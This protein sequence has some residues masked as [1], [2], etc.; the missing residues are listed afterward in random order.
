MNNNRVTLINDNCVFTENMSVDNYVIIIPKFNYA[1][2][3]DSNSDIRKH[4]IY[5]LKILFIGDID[6][7]NYSVTININTNIKNNIIKN[8]KIDD[9]LINIDFV[10]IFDRINKLKIL[11]YD[12]NIDIFNYMIIT[13]SLFYFIRFNESNNLINNNN[14]NNNDNYEVN[15]EDYSFKRNIYINDLH[16]NEYVIYNNKYYKA[17]LNSGYKIIL[18]KSNNCISLV[19]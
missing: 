17:P 18:I 13:D 8:Y 9:P 14:N 19:H 12:F 15:I 6:I 5:S 1:F 11:L 2:K 4:S 16:N 10:N 7:Y 3:I